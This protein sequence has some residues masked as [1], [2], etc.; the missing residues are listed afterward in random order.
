[1]G[2]VQPGWRIAAQQCVDVNQACVLAG[3]LTELAW[4]RKHQGLQRDTPH[5]VGEAKD[6]NVEARHAHSVHTELVGCLQQ[7]L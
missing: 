3:M 5:D 4:P 2:S 1:M 6:G 7:L